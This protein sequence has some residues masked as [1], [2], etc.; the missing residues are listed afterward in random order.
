MKIIVVGNGK[1]GFALSRQLSLEGHDVIIVDNDP[2]AL[3]SSAALDVTTVTGNGVS[4]EVLVEAGIATAD[5]L[6]AVTPSDEGNIIVC[7]MGRK[8]G[9]RHT[10]PRIRNPEYAKDLALIKDELGLSMVVNPEMSAAEEIAR[11]LRFPS[12]L[13]V[14][15]FSRGRIELIEV[16]INAQNP[17]IGLSLAEISKKFRTNILVCTVR[18]G[19]EALIPNGS[20]VLREGDQIGITAAPSDMTAF[21]R[22]AGILQQRIRDVMIVGGSRISFYLSRILLDA[23]MQ[24]KILEFDRS[25]CEVLAELLPKAMI[26]HCDGSDQEVLQEEGIDNTDA[27]VAL[28]GLD[29][30][31]VV[32]SMYAISRNVKKTI[33]KINHITFGDVLKKAG[34]ECIITPHTITTSHIVYYVRAMQ[35]SSGSSFEALTRLVDGQ[36]EAIEFRVMDGFLGKNIPLRDLKLKKNILIGNIIR[37]GRPIYPSGGDCLLPGDSVVVVTTRSGLDELNDILQ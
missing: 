15:F 26:I 37:A 25:R 22:A 12:A 16:S 33:T 18:R 23:G 30:E 32:I 27:L 35:N 8:L 11:I 7:L 31:N 36:A 28:T 2:E 4:R 34:I 29:E 5:L 19:E 6:I 3:E 17:L 24:V 13:K 9:A 21:F 1:L 14:N 10:I 20:F